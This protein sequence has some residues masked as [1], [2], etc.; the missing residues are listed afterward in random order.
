MW[1]WTEGL[2][3]SAC[4]GNVY[5]AEYRSSYNNHVV[6][7]YPFPVVYIT[8]PQLGVNTALKD[9]EDYLVSGFFPSPTV[10]DTEQV[11]KRDLFPSSDG[12]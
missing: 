4:D 12:E 7:I 9:V 2:R 11:S 6:I 5:Y 3:S 8:F 10:L 1:A